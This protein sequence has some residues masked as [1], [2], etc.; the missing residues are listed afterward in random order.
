MTLDFESDYSFPELAERLSF[1]LFG[2]NEVFSKEPHGDGYQIGVGNNWWL[3]QNGKQYRL[4]FRY[5]NPELMESYKIVL[6]HL[7]IAREDRDKK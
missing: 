5:G 4:A 3:H 7:W 2:K 1:F 6:K